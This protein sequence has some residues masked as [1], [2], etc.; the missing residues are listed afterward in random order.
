MS[1]ASAVEFARR[2]AALSV[3]GDRVAMGRIF[4]LAKEF[5]TMEPLQIESML[6]SAD[7]GMRVG[8]VS[9]M[10][11]RARRR[12]TLDSRRTESFELYQRRHDRINTWDLVD[13]AAS[14]VVGR[15]LFDRPR[16]PLYV[17]A[18][19]EPWWE[20]RTAIVATYCFIRQDDVGD[21]SAIADLLAND[22]GSS[23]AEGG[24]RLGSRGR[25]ARHRS[26]ARL[27]RSARTDDASD[28]AAVRR[29]ATRYIRTPL[30][31]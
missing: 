24:G 18:G 8:A 5:V 3:D 12:R 15:Y 11:F 30:R 19:S 21:T 6:D 22:P 10:D 20:R 26:A 28:R 1:T 31:T 2:L 25:Q 23:G 27:P 9:L 7:H 17:L 14:H 29:E 13:R 4:A 16:D